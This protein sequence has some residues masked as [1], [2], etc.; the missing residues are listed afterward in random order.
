MCTP[1]R[2]PAQS[3]HIGQA[4]SQA[5][6]LCT[7]ESRNRGLPFEAAGHVMPLWRWGAL[8]LLYSGLDATKLKFAVLAG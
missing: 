8:D 6:I 5:C 4:V 2:A 1:A 7:P 3:D